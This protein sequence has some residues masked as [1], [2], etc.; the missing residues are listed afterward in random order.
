MRILVVEPGCKPVA[1]KIDGTLKTLQSLVDGYIQAIYPFR[2]EVALICNEEGRLLGLPMNRG[3]RDE[4]GN[5]Y[6]IICGTFLICGVSGDN[7]ASLS[8]KQLQRYTEMY[9][10]PEVF[11][12]LGGCTI[13]LPAQEDAGKESV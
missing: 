3:L 7:F 11:L 13:I 12:N 6:D 4:K 5:L 8:D 2:E 1:M 9:A 10:T